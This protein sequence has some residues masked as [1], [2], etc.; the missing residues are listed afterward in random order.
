MEV[1]TGDRKCPIN[2]NKH[3]FATKHRAAVI[4]NSKKQLQQGAC[5]LYSIKSLW[6][7]VG[8]RFN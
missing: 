2:S 5:V 7:E 3:Q 1:A 8:V 4:K 6:A